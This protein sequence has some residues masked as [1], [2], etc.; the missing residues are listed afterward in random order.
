MA[1]TVHEIAAA[2]RIRIISVPHGYTSCVMLP[3]V[4]QWNVEANRQRQALISAC[5]D[6]PGRS[7]AELLDALIRDLGLPR[8]LAAVGVGEGRLPT[9]ARHVLDDPFGRSNPRPIRTASD[10]M[11]VLRAALGG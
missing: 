2:P 6:E 1:R 8:T 11:P 5:F 7:A 4:M 3:Y 9:I 10:V